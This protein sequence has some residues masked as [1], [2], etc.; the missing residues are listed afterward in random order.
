[1]A[2]K[3][4]YVFTRDIL[5]NS[6]LNLMHKHW[7][8]DLGYLIHPRISTK[9][10]NLRIADI[11]TGTAIWLLDTYDELPKSARFDGLD[12]SLE[13]APPLN[14]LPPNITLTK[15]NVKDPV[16]EDLL[17][18]FDIIHIRFFIFVLLGEEV[19]VVVEKFVAMLR[20]YLQW[21]DSDNRSVRTE[22]PKPGGQPENVDEVQTNNLDQLMSLLKSQDPRLNPTWVP[23]LPDIFSRGG[24]VDVETDIH[25]SPPHLGFLMHECGLIMHELIAR[26]TK[27][28]K[29]AQEVKRLLPLAVEETR[30]GA[31]L[32]STKFCVTGRKP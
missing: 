32:T 11:G 10:E 29:M 1:M 30:Q 2:S 6:R 3:D 14:V 8:K 24:L 31:Y 12:I 25:D 26:K 17:G 15:W 21:V 18:V 28:E 4:D 5:D 16:P 20:G 27:N 7:V 9:Q 19:P 13:A 22:R 23:E